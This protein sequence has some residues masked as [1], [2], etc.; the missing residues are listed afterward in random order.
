MQAEV[1]AFSS[2]GR[3]DVEKTQKLL[4]IDFLLVPGPHA[5]LMK[6]YGAYNYQKGRAQPSTVIIDKTGVLRWKYIGASNEDRPSVE[7]I[8][9][10]LKLVQ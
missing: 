8:L 3:E 4:N 9:N 10:Q 2:R 1:I 7:T 5:E 6:E